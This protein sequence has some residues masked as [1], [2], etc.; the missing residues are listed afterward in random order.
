M[1]KK[2]EILHTARLTLKAFEPCDKPQMM[3]IFYNKEI[4][5]TYMLPDFDSPAQAEALFQKMMNISRAEDRFEYGIYLDHTL[6]GFINDCEIKGTSIELG[7]VIAPA[8]QGQGF[9]TEA[10]GICIQELFAMGF[11]Q[12]KAGFFEGNIA[13]CRVM[14]KCG[15]HKIDFEEDIEYRGLLRHCI[16]YAIEK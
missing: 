10:L 11:A 4:K 2:Q 1:K 9:A 7:Y 14:Q 16:Y 6:I 3:E 15:M 13:S 12:V 8:Y 5:K